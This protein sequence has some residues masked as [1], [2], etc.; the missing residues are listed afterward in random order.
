[1]D[2]SWPFSYPAGYSGE[3]IAPSC[4]SMPSWSKLSQL[5]TTL[6][7]EKRKMP[8]PVKLTSLPVGAMPLNSPR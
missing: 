7:S 6:P 8:I 4:L 2:V 3:E 5:S 1:V